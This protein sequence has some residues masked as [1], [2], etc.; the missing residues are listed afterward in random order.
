MQ[1]LCKLDFYLRDFQLKTGLEKS[2]GESSEKLRES[3][4]KVCSKCGC[5]GIEN[6]DV[7]CWQESGH[8]LAFISFAQSSII[9]AAGDAK[10][11]KNW[12]VSS[13]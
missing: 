5:G 1:V 11:G 12:G 4:E 8:F 9:P 7:V 3:V 13:P 10:E 2:G 6:V